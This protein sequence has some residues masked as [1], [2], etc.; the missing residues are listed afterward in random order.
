MWRELV[1]YGRHVFVA[2]A[3]L[4]LGELGAN[5]II[6]RFLGTASLGQ[7]RYAL[8]LARHARSRCCS[9]APPTSSSPRSRGSRTTRTRLRDAFM[10]SLRW[11]CV[12]AF[13]AGMV[14]LPLGVPMAVIVFGDVWRPAGE[15][16]AAMCLFPAG[17]MLADG[18]LRGR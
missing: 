6:G 8:R 17:G 11:V 3:V 12:L 10:R 9:P 13:P 4:H 15:A 18:R 2:T 14:F 16:L 7:F 1:G 5:A